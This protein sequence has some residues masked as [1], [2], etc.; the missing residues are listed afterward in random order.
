[1][2]DD[3]LVTRRLSPGFIVA[4]RRF[5]EEGDTVAVVRRIRKVRRNDAY[6]RDFPVNYRELH[7]K[8]AQ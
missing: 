7:E 1:M 3:P 8:F 6:E 5:E 4:R 2:T